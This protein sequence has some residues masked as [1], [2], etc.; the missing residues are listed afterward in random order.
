MGRVD[1]EEE[2]CGGAG[3]GRQGGAGD[4]VVRVDGGVGSKKTYDP[5]SYMAKAE[6]SMAAR[7]MQACEDLQSA[8]TTM[9]G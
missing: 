6:T 4:G 5:R 9:A 8:G 7:V 3:A 1:G 2:V